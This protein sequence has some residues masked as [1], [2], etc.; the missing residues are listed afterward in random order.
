MELSRSFRSNHRFC[1]KK[2]LELWFFNLQ[3]LLDICKATNLFRR[4]SQQSWIYEYNSVLTLTVLSNGFSGLDLG[5]ASGTSSDYLSCDCNRTPSLTSLDVCMTYG[6]YHS[7]RSFGLRLFQFHFR[8]T[9][10]LCQMRRKPSQQ[11]LFYYY[12]FCG[13]RGKLNFCTFY[14]V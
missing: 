2:C 9:K 14:G 5:E 4:R 6:W 1:K 10:L 13:W 11:F 12:V 7:E 3:H 8:V